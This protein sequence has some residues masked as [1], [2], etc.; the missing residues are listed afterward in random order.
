M[1]RNAAIPTAAAAQTTL[2]SCCFFPALIV[3]VV[4]RPSSPSP[5]WMFSDSGIE[6]ANQ[7]FDLRKLISSQLCNELFS[8]CP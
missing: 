7:L 4:V 6:I 8:F 3:V 1:V 5:G 2:K